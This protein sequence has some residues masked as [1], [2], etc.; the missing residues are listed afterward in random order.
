MGRFRLATGEEARPW[1]EPRAL[2]EEEAE[3]LLPLRHL[4]QSHAKVEMPAGNLVALDKR[5]GWRPR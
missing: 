4:R 5:S 1:L 3:R 2:R